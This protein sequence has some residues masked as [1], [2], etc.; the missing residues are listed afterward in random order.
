M[1]NGDE[2]AFPGGGLQDGM[3]LRDWFAG[4]A[5]VGLLAQTDKALPAD[6]FAQNAYTVADA[7]LEARKQ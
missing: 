7:M 5:V 1:K 2:K 4:Q 6:T 3:S